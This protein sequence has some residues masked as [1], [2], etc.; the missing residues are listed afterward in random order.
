MGKGP[1]LESGVLRLSI[2]G[3]GLPIADCGLPIADC[4]LSVESGV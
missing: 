2:A 4:R 3:C 1:S